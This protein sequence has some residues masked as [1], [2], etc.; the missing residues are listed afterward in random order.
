MVRRSDKDPGAALCESLRKKRDERFRRVGAP[1]VG[2][3]EAPGRADQLDVSLHRYTWFRPAA[4]P[5][6]RT[7]SILLVS[8]RN[9]TM[10]YAQLKSATARWHEWAGFALGLWLAMS[11]WICGYADESHTATGNAAFMGIA[12]ALGS[13]F[14]LFLDAAAAEWLHLAAGAWLAAA[15]FILGFGATPVPAINCIAVGTLVM[16]L[17][18]SALSLDKEIEKWWQKRSSGSTE[19]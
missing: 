14:Q 12:L 9:A 17:A 13:H 2:A 16:A 10:E 5:A 1:G 11:P 7:A 18:A 6:A 8:N 15:P 4:T 19:A 3:A